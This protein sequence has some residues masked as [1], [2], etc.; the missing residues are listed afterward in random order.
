MRYALSL[1]LVAAMLL[2]VLAPGAGAGGDGDL[3]LSNPSAGTYKGKVANASRK[4]RRG[5]DVTVVHDEDEDGYDRDDFSI[6]D[7]RTN[8]RG[9][10][11]MTG[12]PQAPPGDQIA[13][14]AFKEDNCR[15][16]TVVAEAG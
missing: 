14:K 15:A 1:A 8:R 11:E 12:R 7:D 5:R 3:T 9:R 10:Y 16:L 13:A 2:A 6:G 4:C